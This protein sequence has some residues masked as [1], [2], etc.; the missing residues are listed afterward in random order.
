MDVDDEDDEEWLSAQ[1]IER[2]AR[3]AKRRGDAGSRWLRNG[4]GQKIGVAVEMVAYKAVCHNVMGILAK[5]LSAMHGATVMGHSEICLQTENI[6]VLPPLAGVPNAGSDSYAEQDMMKSL[7][8]S[9][10]GD[11]STSTSSSFYQHPARSLQA[12]ESAV[13]ETT[14]SMAESLQFLDRW[15]ERMLGGDQIRTQIAA[16]IA[17]VVLSLI[18]DILCQSRMDLWS[19]HAGGPR[20]LAGLFYRTP[21]SAPSIRHES[22]NSNNAAKQSAF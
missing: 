5:S 7:E 20:L 4:L 8:R 13:E 16:L 19:S 22:T 12:F 1:E 9:M 2:R 15:H 17:R 14:K 21:P 3:E 6:P 11:S 10:S 18:D